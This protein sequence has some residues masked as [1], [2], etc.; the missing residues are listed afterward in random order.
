MCSVDP[1]MLI[2]CKLYENTIILLPLYKTDYRV[3]I[4][5]KDK[6]WLHYLALSPGDL[7]ARLTTEN[8]FI[9]N[10]FFTK[11]HKVEEVIICILGV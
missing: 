11:N 5:K 10:K 2:F 6:Y 9:G 4:K 1:G 7:C 8:V 3:K